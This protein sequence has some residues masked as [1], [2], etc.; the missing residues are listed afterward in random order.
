MFQGRSTDSRFVSKF[1]CLFLFYFQSTVS[2]D[3]EFWSGVF[4]FQY[5]KY[6]TPF[7]LAY[8]VSDE[9]SDVILVFV[10][11]REGVFST[12]NYFN[13]FSIFGSC[14]LNMVYQRVDY[15]AFCW[16]F[17][18]LPGSVV[19][20]LVINFGESSI[21]ITSSISSFSLCYKRCMEHVP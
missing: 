8:I 19:W 4:P 20:C 11:Y 2:L 14:N 6:F 9:V 21:I 5:L 16:I 3:T 7:L 17:S 15:W 18:E 13:I 10:F 12:W 1:V